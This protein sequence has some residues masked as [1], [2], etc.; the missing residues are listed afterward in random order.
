MSDIWRTGRATSL[1]FRHA[2]RIFLFAF[3]LPF[4]SRS[5]G[6][7]QTGEFPI[8]G[9]Q[10]GKGFSATVAYRQATKEVIDCCELCRRHSSVVFDLDKVAVGA[11]PELLDIPIRNAMSPSATLGRNHFLLPFSPC[12]CSA[13]EAERRCRLVHTNKGPE[14]KH[15]KGTGGHASKEG[16]GLFHL[17]PPGNAVSNSNAAF[18][19]QGWQM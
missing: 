15:H 3:P 12:V 1:V 4:Q 8:C 19:R 11:G 10:T 6:R 16:R 5:S 18:L 9:I 2:A 13:V 17:S 7:E 14:K